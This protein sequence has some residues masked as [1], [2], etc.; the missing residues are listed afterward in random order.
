MPQVFY[1][2]YRPKSFSEVIGQE[3]V[4]QTLTNALKS[5]V[6]SHGYLFSGPRGSGK[7]TLARLFAKAL[8]CQK[9]KK[10]EAEPCNSCDS[11]IFR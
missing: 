7:T 11:A 3:H 4:I 5:G 1:R 9:R 8:N 6:I 10:G 2:K